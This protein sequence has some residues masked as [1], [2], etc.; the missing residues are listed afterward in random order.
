MESLQSA[1]VNTE[2]RMERLVQPG[3]EC[4]RHLVAILADF[5]MEMSGGR[6][7]FLCRQ[8]VDRHSEWKAAQQ[9]LQNP[10][11][12]AMWSVL[13]GST[14]QQ[15]QRELEEGVLDIQRNMKWYVEQQYPLDSDEVQIEMQR[16]KDYAATFLKLKYFASWSP[17]FNGRELELIEGMSVP[18]K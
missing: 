18:E 11:N 9:R 17:F 3:R 2:S 16:K 4:Q 13:V 10:C 5:D 1:T 14:V 7:R 6:L 15:V 12:L 8:V